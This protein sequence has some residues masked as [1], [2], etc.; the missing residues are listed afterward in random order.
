MNTRRS[1]MTIAR[2][3]VRRSCCRLIRLIGFTLH[4][5]LLVFVGLIFAAGLP[6]P[7][8]AQFEPNGWSLEKAVQRS[9]LIF[10]GSVVDIAFRDSEPPQ[11]AE[12]SIPH[13]FVTYRIDE[14]LRGESTSRRMTLRFMGGWS[15]ETGKIILAYGAPLFRLGDR[16]ILFVTANGAASCPLVACGLGRFRVN[17]GR[18]F[19]DTGAAIRVDVRGR[20]QAGPDRLPSERLSMEF[21]PAPEARLEEMRRRIAEDDLDEIERVRLER[22]LRDN[23]GSRVLSLGRWVGKPPEPPAAPPLELAAFKQMITMIGER[24]PASG[25]AVLPASLDDPIRMNALEPSRPEKPPGPPAGP[26]SRPMSREQLLLQRN[27]GNPVLGVD[28]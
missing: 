26:P 23:S 13:T 15:S 12:A 28:R 18:I 9:R 25:P 22:R 24:Y 17:E 5:S 19:T 4:G 2:G 6:D 10:E 14:I 3:A 11:G 27:N 20:L 8:N 16:D 1:H 7:A 21:P